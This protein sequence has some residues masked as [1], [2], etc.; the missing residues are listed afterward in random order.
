MVLVATVL[1][2]RV[3]IG[4]IASSNGKV[5]KATV[6]VECNKTSEVV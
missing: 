5:H 6:L 4:I 2:I 3:F 1:Y